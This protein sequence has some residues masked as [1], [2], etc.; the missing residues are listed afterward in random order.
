MTKDIIE[1]DPY[2]SA[3]VDID[4]GEDLIQKIKSDVSLTHN[5]NVIGDI[6]GFA[7]MY[8]LPKEFKNPIM[9][10][11]T[12]GVGTKVAL[13]QEYGNL[14]GIGQDLVAM[15][16]NDLI[17]C[18]AKPLFF[19]DYYATSKLRVDEA[20]IVIKSISKACIDSGCSLL[21]GETA[22]MPGHY[23]DN[24]FDLAGFSVGCVEEDKIISSENVS[25]G[26]LLIGIESSGPHSNGFSLIRKILNN[27][28]GPLNFKEQMIIEALSPTLLYPKVILN[29][30]EKYQVNSMSHITGGGLVENLPRSVP[31][32]LSVEIDSESWQMPPIFEWLKSDGNI[33]QHDM[34]RIFNCGI[35]LVL[36][37]NEVDVDPIMKEISLNDLN[38]FIIGRV[39]EKNQKE[40]VVFR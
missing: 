18:G 19:L 6:G 3:G 26:N 39:M 4:A 27:Y 10:A 31:K 33:L 30:L 2:R 16:V 32:N 38:S 29:I 35:G 17:I 15:C 14:K 22:E 25:V 21:G 13:A 23:I 37:V 34:Y 20:S 36:I 8:R 11:C 1:N 40:S 7:G 12:D 5:E 28:D 9:V 24:N